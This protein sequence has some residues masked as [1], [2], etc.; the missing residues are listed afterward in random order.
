MKLDNKNPGVIVIVIAGVLVVIGIVVF[1]IIQN[2]MKAMDGS[3]TQDTTG[4][5]INTDNGA[6]V[7][8]SQGE[9]GATDDTGNTASNYENAPIINDDT[10]VIETDGGQAY[11]ITPG[12]SSAGESDIIGIV[13]N[14]ED[15]SGNTQS[16]TSGDGSGNASSGNASSGNTSSGNGD[17]NGSGSDSSG[18][19][20]NT[21]VYETERIPI[22]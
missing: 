14:T 8:G 6:G 12:D 10:E 19:D 20:E 13:P 1:I 22:N 18:E 16:D 3:T 11:T 4:V 9:D 5:V 17:S 15:T 2:R 21:T 7:D